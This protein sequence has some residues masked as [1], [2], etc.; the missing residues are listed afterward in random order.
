[1]EQPTRSNLSLGEERLKLV[2]RILFVSLECQ[3]L[4]LS[5]ACLIKRFNLLSLRD[6]ASFGLKLV[7]HSVRVAS[8][9]EPIRHRFKVG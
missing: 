7:G 9:L 1:M 5:P 2:P 3:I 8:N 6:C 4:T